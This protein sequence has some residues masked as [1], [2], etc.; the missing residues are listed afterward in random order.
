MLGDEGLVILLQQAVADHHQVQR[1]HA[2]KAAGLLVV[3]HVEGR[4][5]ALRLTQPIDRHRGRRHHQLRPTRRALEHQ[6][7]GLHRLAQAHVIR[8][9]GAHAPLGQTRQ[10]GKA[11]ALVIAQLGLQGARH[12]W[13][14][15]LQGFEALQM[16]LPV[17]VG[18]ELTGFVRQPSKQRR[19][20][21]VETQAVIVNPVGQVGQLIQV[22]AQAA[23]EGQPIL[24]TE[25]EKTPFV[26]FQ[27]L[28]QL[29]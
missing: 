25:L 2:F 22:L 15:I 18:L 1:T 7:Q 10:P 24:I 21:Q 29:P 8:Q 13:L 17:L 19:G 5:K 20:Q 12:L 6:R 4:R 16:A 3:V 23:A 28:Q 27:Q 9:A 14:E 26:G 11:L